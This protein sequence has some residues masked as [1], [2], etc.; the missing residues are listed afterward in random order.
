MGNQH[1]SINYS[2]LYQYKLLEL[3]L[4][5]DF[6][7]KITQLNKQGLDELEKQK[8]DTSLKKFDE[9]VNLFEQYL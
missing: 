6:K 8:L 1:S 7:M 2:A 3:Y 5:E 4:Y 9:I